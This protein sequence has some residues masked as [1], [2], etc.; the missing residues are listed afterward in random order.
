[1]SHAD[2]CAIHNFSVTSELLARN[3]SDF[4]QRFSG[5][6]NLRCSTRIQVFAGNQTWVGHFEREKDAEIKGIEKERSK[7]AAC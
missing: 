1:M 4:E 2:F 7:F 6:S 3:A 5:K